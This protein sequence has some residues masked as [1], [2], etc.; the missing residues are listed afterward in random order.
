MAPLSFLHG[1]V[2]P[3]GIPL[4]DFFSERITES[5][6]IHT[7]LDCL[8]S[9]ADPAIYSPDPSAPPLPHDALRAF[10]STFAL[11]YSA[12][13]KALGPNDRVM[14][15][16]PTGP[17]NAVALLSVASYHTCAP[18]NA[19]C[20][21]SEMKDDAARLNVKAILT[22][23]DA[24]DRLELLQL[25]K[26]LDC[27][28]I[29][30]AGRSSGPAGI[31]DMSLMGGVASQSPLRP[32]KLH[33]LDD[34]SLVLHTSGTSGKKKVVPYKLR[35]LIIGTSAVVQSWNLQRTDVN[36]ESMDSTCS[37]TKYLTLMQ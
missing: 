27:E 14:V 35:S 37:R 10:V 25:Q 26:E 12:T 28:V 8:C 9:T 20:T 32:S 33:S 21:P 19:S 11:P 3:T 5:N 23:R 30:I 34:Q 15:V 2:A 36:C 31:F 6:T 16:L 24:E 13:R 1:F 17:E 22:T 7:L 18:V 29:Y 4:G